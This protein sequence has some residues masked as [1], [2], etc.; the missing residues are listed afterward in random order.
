MRVRKSFSRMPQ[1]ARDAFLAALMQMKNTIANPGDL[2]PISFYDQFVLIHNAA[3][4]AISLGG[5]SPVDP[6]H[7]ASAFG[8]W[9]REFLL[10]FELVLQTFDSTVMLP[11][12]DWTDGPGNTNIIFNEFG[13]GPNG[14]AA[15]QNHMLTGYFAPDRPG[16][17]ANSTPLPSW[18]AATMMGLF[19]RP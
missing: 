2:F 5:A 15:S 3:D 8:P 12:W 4:S 19:F 7:Q 6:A 16:T 13:M 14:S 11:Y 17:G 9:H 1:P 18:Y 10:R